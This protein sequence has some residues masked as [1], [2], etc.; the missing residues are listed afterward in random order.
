MIGS[1]QN[2]AMDIEVIYTLVILFAAV[3]FFVT[4]W[5]RVD[6]VALAVVVALMLTNVLSPAQALAGFSSTA[7]LTIAALFIVG[8]GVMQTGLAAI[9]GE[10]I[11]QIAGTDETRLTVVIMLAVALLSGF[12]SD[13]GTVAV[14]L[15][16]IVA[17]AGSAKISPSRLLIPLSYGSLLGGAMTMI[18]TPSNIIV[19]DLLRDEGLE[20]FSFFSFT[21]MGILLMVTGIAFMLIVGRRI[22]P[23]YKSAT[24]DLRVS[25]PVELLDI[26][27]LPD[28]IYRLRVMSDSSLVGRSLAD[29]NLRQELNVTVL[30]MQRHPDPHVFVKFGTHQVMLQ[31][32]KL[33]TIY[34]DKETKIHANDLLLA[35]G[36]EAAIQKAA[37]QW[38]LK[39]LP[40]T[41]SD[42]DVL[43]NQ[44]GGIAEVL[45]RPR[46]A[47]TGKTL[48]EIRFGTRS[49][50]W[51]FLFVDQEP[52]KLLIPP[53][54]PSNPVMFCLF[55]AC[56]KIFYASKKSI[57]PTSLYWGSQKLKP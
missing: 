46:S 11:L 25:T 38:N 29:A 35:Q 28:D 8:G 48:A 42:Q 22:L 49:D 44:E 10:Y 45:V 33:D 5:L 24:G 26:Y 39:M 3:I 9:I 36:K 51:S 21:P 17:L 37:S 52:T 43:V 57:A 55:K 2:T 53:P 15:P 12:M 27:R 56:G 19:S 40:K 30:E 18:G 54:P 32:D 31:S 23:D 7:V 41:Q 1:L 34:P 20:P 47:F 6:V 13:T 50:W 4:E 16:A 14:L